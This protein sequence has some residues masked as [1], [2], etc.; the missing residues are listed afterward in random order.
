MSDN[1]LNERRILYAVGVM[2][3]QEMDE[4]IKA[5]EEEAAAQEDDDE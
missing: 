5:E 4:K 2:S 1:D 3:K